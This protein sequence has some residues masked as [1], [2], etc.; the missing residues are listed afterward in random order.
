MIL[1][2]KTFIY[3]LTVFG[4]MLPTSALAV[5]ASS[6]IGAPNVLLEMIMN[7]SN[8]NGLSAGQ[9]QAPVG[10]GDNGLGTISEPVY[11]NCFT[12]AVSNISPNT[13]G[14]NQP[15]GMNRHQRDFLSKS[16]N[17]QALDAAEQADIYGKFVGKVEFYDKTVFW[18]GELDGED[19]HV[20]IAIMQ[21]ARKEAKEAAMQ[22]IRSASKSFNNNKGA[23][24]QEARLA[25][26]QAMIES[27]RTGCGKGKGK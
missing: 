22:E 11:I 20:A 3:F 14:T 12:E 17:S 1:P 16:L 10:A 15:D 6:S 26:R 7:C 23:L 19:R 8:R 18:L 5:E 13:P 21:E 24:M 9:S 2:R 27:K 4:L 25:A